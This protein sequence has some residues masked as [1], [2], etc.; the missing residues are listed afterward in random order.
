MTSEVLVMCQDGKG[1][2]ILDN[3]TLT[4]RRDYKDMF[5]GVVPD[6][7]V[8]QAYYKSSMR[9]YLVDNGLVYDRATNSLT[10]D[11]TVNLI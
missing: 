8:P 1:G 6:E 2:K 11:V 5:F 10:P 3:I 4:K 9:E 7:V